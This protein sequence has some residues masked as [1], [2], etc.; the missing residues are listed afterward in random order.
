MFATS[1]YA[2]AKKSYGNAA[3]GARVE[4]ASPHEL[5]AVLFEE[6][7][8]HLDTLAAGLS[9]NGTMTRVAALERKARV[10]TILHGL[11]ASLDFNQG[12][13]ISRGLA[14]IYREARRLV[15]EGT[16]GHDPKP[17]ILAREMVAQIADAWAQI[18]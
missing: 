14:S 15:T 10:A 17:I 18:A 16:V 5:V 1:G 4:A 7:L 6:L 11:E 13:E 2:A 8:K 3:L 9:A 12:G